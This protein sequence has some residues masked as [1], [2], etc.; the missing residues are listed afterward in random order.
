MAAWLGE[1][2]GGSDRP[3]VR[4]TLSVNDA[5]PLKT[6][7]YSAWYRFRYGWQFQSS[8]PLDKSPVWLLGRCYHAEDPLEESDELGK[9]GVPPHIVQLLDH[10][11]SLSWMTYRTNFPPITDTVLTSDCGWGCMVRS[12]Q[13]LLA[14]A[15]HY[16]LLDRDWRLSSSADRDKATHA[17]IL[18]WFADSPQQLCPFSLH[19]LMRQAEVQGYRPGDWYGP[20][21]VA[22]IMARCLER[23]KSEHPTLKK[24]LVYLARDCTVYMKDV[25]HLFDVNDGGSLLLLVPI[26]LGGESLNPIYIPCV[27]NLLSLDHCIGIIGGKPKHSVYFVGFQDDKLLNL[28]PHYCQMAVSVTSSADF[29]IRS[30]HCRTP[31]KLTA[32]KMDPS[33]TIGFFCRSRDDFQVLR[34]KTEPVLAPPKQKGVYPFFTFADLSLGDVIED[35]TLGQVDISTVG[36]DGT[37]SSRGY[38]TVD[39]RSF[40]NYSD[41][42]FLVVECRTNSASLTASLPAPVLQQQQREEASD[43]AA[44][45][46]KVTVNGSGATCSDTEDSP[47]T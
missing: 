17:Q 22:S 43:D 39:T 15:L 27:Q 30:Y 33:C 2:S 5:I 38:D 3:G 42:D 8:V 46:S 9:E 26:R 14:T 35:A 34:R 32:S 16:Y 28:D 4:R 11:H 6:R 25:E 19:S 45:D 13:M 21:Q 37:H 12:G 41:E 7:V 24:L 31:R 44:Q 29:D 18:S 36:S 47:K 23:A 10:Y 1:G 40:D 20:S